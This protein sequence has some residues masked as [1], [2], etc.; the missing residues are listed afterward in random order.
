[1]SNLDPEQD[2]SRLFAEAV[3]TSNSYDRSHTR[4]SHAF[5]KTYPTPSHARPI[6]SPF[7]AIKSG[8]R[9]D[10]SVGEGSGFWAAKRE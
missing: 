10:R 4:F 9:T 7:L 3:E 2:L 1:M 6:V 8:S 5:N